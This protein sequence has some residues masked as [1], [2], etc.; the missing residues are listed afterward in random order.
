MSKRRRFRRA[1]LVLIFLL[2]VLVGGWTGV[3]Y[4]LAGR[5]A[6]NL[7][8][9][10]SQAQAAG[11]VIRHDPP[12]R[13][14]WPM[15]AGI[16]LTHVSVEADQAALPGGAVWQAAQVTL[17]RDIRHSGDLFIG[18][19]GRQSIALGHKPPV[20]FQA[21]K[22]AALAAL[23]PD[24]RLGLIQGNASA[25]L[26]AW[27]AGEG[28]V[29]PV[30]ITAMAAAL[31]ADGPETVLAMQLQGIGLPRSHMGALGNPKFL[32]FDTVISGPSAA[33][34]LALCAFTLE[35]G[36][37]T[38]NA[39]GR[40]ALA[41]RQKPKGLLSVSAK[42]LNVALEKLADEKV[43]TRAEARAMGAVAGLVMTADMPAALSLDDGLVRL[44]PIPLF[45]WPQ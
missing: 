24:G 2:L 39:T 19:D 7:T 28:K 33:P 22:M 31:Q 41:A 8:A 3:W 6:D 9:W 25:I 44:G 27:P 15:A 45:R 13:T 21:Q 11:F 37:L 20:A 40:L 36:P 32:S 35:D 5:L 38:L 23:L 34:Q 42:G 17:A 1:F 10:E 16:R 29:Q 43:M 18:I 30:S 4:L 12:V 26:A 14:G